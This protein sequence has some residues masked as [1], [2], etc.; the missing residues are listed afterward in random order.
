[1]NRPHVAINAAISLD[2]KL[3]GRQAPLQVSRAD[4]RHMD[5]LRHGV[6]AILLGAATLR[7]NDYPLQLRCPV[8]QA[9]RRSH[10][11][12]AGIACVLVSRGQALMPTAR[13]FAQPQAPFLAVA[14][15]AGAP[16]LA[17]P[18]EHWRCSAP[19]AADVDWRI[20]LGRL[21]ARGVHRLL[22]EAGGNVVGQL[23]DGGHVDDLHLTLCPRLLGPGPS[24][25]AGS[26]RPGPT[27]RL[28]TCVERDGEI[29]LHYTTQG[30]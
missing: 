29:F 7:A 25:S 10:G 8:A 21:A 27:M 12:P 5:F 23:L 16:D 18:A 15:P 20:L 30:A 2:G 26:Q 24:L 28:R 14:T 11:L 4:R 13:F 9:L 3:A 22:V 1:M 6:D 19:D 17:L